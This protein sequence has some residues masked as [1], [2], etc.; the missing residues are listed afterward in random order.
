MSQS[1]SQSQNKPP[2]QNKIQQ[3]MKPKSK[4]KVI[5]FQT[6]DITEYFKNKNR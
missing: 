3:K 4:D 1:L 6:E 5:S 2:E